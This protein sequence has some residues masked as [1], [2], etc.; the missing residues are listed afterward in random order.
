MKSAVAV[1]GLLTASVGAIELTK[2]TWDEATA[3]KAVFVKFQA[4]W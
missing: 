2:E 3:G 1:L 4:P